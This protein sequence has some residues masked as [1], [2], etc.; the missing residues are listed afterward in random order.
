MNDGML[1]SDPPCGWW[2][3]VHCMAVGFRHDQAFAGHKLQHASCVGCDLLLTSEWP[4]GMDAFLAN[5]DDTGEAVLVGSYD[6]A[7]L[8][9]RLKSARTIAGLTRMRASDEDGLASTSKLVLAL[10]RPYHCY[11]A[12]VSMSIQRVVVDFSVLVALVLC[13]R[14]NIN[15]NVSYRFM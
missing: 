3:R 9:L 15:Y 1:R 7:E 2:R 6:V 8:A 5:E 10:V 11:Q 4:Q 13:S 14:I 12:V